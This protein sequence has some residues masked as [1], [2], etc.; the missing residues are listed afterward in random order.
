MNFGIDDTTIAV[1][2]GTAL[3]LFVLLPLMVPL[4]IGISRGTGGRFWRNTLTGMGMGVLTIA[5]VIG[6]F[7]LLA[8]TRVITGTTFCPTFIG[9]VFGIVIGA[10]FLTR[11]VLNRLAP[12][13][14]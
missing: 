6:W 13:D 5:A 12:R 3:F 7:P 11:W 4:G 1:L 14:D 10:F 8:N 9:G 2:I